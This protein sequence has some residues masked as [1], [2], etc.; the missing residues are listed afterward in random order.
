M[1]LEQ[2]TLSDEQVQDIIGSSLGS[3][4]A[5]DDPNNIINNT[6]QAG[7]SLAIE[8]DVSNVSSATFS[9]P[10]GFSEHIISISNLIATDFDGQFQL[11]V[12]SDGGST[13]KT[14]YSSASVGFG[15][16]TAKHRVDQTKNKAKLGT[17]N[18]KEHKTV[19]EIRLFDARDSSKNTTFT[20]QKFN[21]QNTTN[22]VAFESGGGGLNSN[23]DDDA[24][25]FDYQFGNIEQATV[26]IRGVK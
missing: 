13:F 26:R 14:G 15:R 18:S 9:I 10:S 1:S 3:G 20:Y 22:G 12:S 6:V 24:V 8:T 4:L 2:L 16:N 11:Q 21:N 23:S 19:Y 25:K 7:V 17:G 5:Y